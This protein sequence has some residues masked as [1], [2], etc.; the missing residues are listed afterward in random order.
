MMGST[1]HCEATDWDLPWKVREAFSGVLMYHLASRRKCKNLPS[2][3]SLWFQAC[4]FLSICRIHIIL[5]EFRNYFSL[6]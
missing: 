3:S 5:L 1:G 2:P 6:T 4:P